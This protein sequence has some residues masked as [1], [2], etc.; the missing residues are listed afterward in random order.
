MPEKYKFEQIGFAY[1]DYL[2]D[3]SMCSG[4][5]SSISFPANAA[6]VSE[7][8]AWCN[9]HKIPV[10]PQGA[11]TGLNGAC[12]PTAGHIMNVAKMNK[13]LSTTS[14]DRL[15]TNGEKA[16]GIITVEAGVTL[17]QLEK[18]IK[19]SFADTRACFPITPTESTATIGG[20]LSNCSN[21]VESYYYGGVHTYIDWIEVC[22]ADGSIQRC[23]QGEDLFHA[24]IGGEGMY[25]MVTSASL[26]VVRRPSVTWGL[27]FFFRSDEAAMAFADQIDFY[28]GK[29]LESRMTKLFA[30]EYMDRNTVDIISRFQSGMPGISGL[31]NIPPQ[32]IAL[33]HLELGAPTDDE[34]ADAAEQLMQ[35]AIENGAD[36][37]E[38]WAMAGYHEVQ[39]LKNY[40][41]AAAECVNMVMAQN[42]QNNSGLTLLSSDIRFPQKDRLEMLKGYQRDL[43]A[44]NL[45]YCMFGHIGL[46]H[47]YVN[48]LSQNQK[49]YEAGQILL[50]EWTREAASSGGQIWVDHGV[51]KLK[52][53]VYA[54]ALSKDDCKRLECQKLK[55]DPELLL[56]PGNG[57]AAQALT[58]NP[59]KNKE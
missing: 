4:S 45:Q 49:E 38:A 33:I 39:L 6:E 50:K 5:A 35:F 14:I 30:L 37:D 57:I 13:I 47:L 7:Q 40:R 23:H 44:A 48:I 10:T 8:L 25:G 17:Q 21:G 12:V 42:R 24:V 32:T 59:E 27:L 41:H 46:K 16:V 54:Q 18:E 28:Y 1:E 20:V 51:G 34:M 31:Q 52:A 58:K 2:R 3:E 9:L 26:Y 43:S 29:T 56:N 11:R 36:P 22:L 19:K 15:L 53:K 55:W